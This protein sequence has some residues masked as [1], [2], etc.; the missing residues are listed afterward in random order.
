MAAEFG[1]SE[2]VCGGGWFANS[3][4]YTGVNERMGD[5]CGRYFY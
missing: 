4:T 5:G 2:D 1:Q 3:G